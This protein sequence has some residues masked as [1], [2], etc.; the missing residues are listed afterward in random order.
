ML[1]CETIDLDLTKEVDVYENAIE[2]IKYLQ[3][4]VASIEKRVLKGENIEGLER[5]QGMKRRSVTDFGLE[6]LS[7][8]FGREF[9]Y[10]SIEKPI[11]IGQL[12]EKLSEEEV[13]ELTKRGVIAYKSSPK[14]IIKR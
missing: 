13:I 1:L 5:V 9:A 6:Y 2:T 14:I 7:K 8:E 10:T 4:V 12:V 11:T 3:D